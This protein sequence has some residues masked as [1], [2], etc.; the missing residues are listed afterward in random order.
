[1]SRYKVQTK[2][3]ELTA[4][5]AVVGGAEDCDYILIVYPIMSLHDQ[6]M[7]SCNQI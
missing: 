7:G 3:A 2:I 6:L 1:M 4:S 5:V